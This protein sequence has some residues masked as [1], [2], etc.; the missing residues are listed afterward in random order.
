M[1][2]LWAVVVRGF[3]LCFLVAVAVAALVVFSFLFFFCYGR[4][5]CLTRSG[6]I[7]DCS[8]LI[9]IPLI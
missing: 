1:Q 6:D 5:M 4:S 8:F 9:R 2:H 3:S 7:L